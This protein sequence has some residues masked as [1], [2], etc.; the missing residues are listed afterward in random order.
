MIPRSAVC[1]VLGAVVLAGSSFASNSEKSSSSACGTALAASAGDARALDLLSAFDGD[2]APL[3][4]HLRQK[5]AQSPGGDAAIACLKSQAATPI[6]RELSLRFWRSSDVLPERLRHAVVALSWDGLP[7]VRVSLHQLCETTTFDDP[8]IRYGE[9]IDGSA[10][11]SGEV[12]SNGPPYSPQQ[13]AQCSAKLSR[14]R[15]LSLHR[16]VSEASA[17]AIVS[18]VPKLSS[19]AISAI[20]LRRNVLRAVP[21]ELRSFEVSREISPPRTGLGTD[22]EAVSPMIRRCKDLRRLRLAHV[23]VTSPILTGLPKE[24]EE[25]ELEEVDTTLAIPFARA[26]RRLESLE[27]L[28]V[29]GL[30]ADGIAALAPSIRRLTLKAPRIAPGAV[31]TRLSRYLREL[32]LHSL[33]SSESA[34]DGAAFARGIGKMT[35]LRRLRLVRCPTTPAYLETLSSKLVAL[36]VE[37]HD[38]EPEI[39]DSALEQYL[40][41]STLRELTVDGIGSQGRFLRWVPSTLHALTL[42]RMA[43]GLAQRAPGDVTDDD[44]Q[45]AFRRAPE[46][47]WLS[48]FAV[49]VEGTFL[50]DLPEALRYFEVD[51]IGMARWEVELPLRPLTLG[52][53]RTKSLT[54]FVCPQAVVRGDIVDVLPTSIVELE[55]A[56]FLRPVAR[57][58]LGDYDLERDLFRRLFRRLSHLRR[59]STYEWHRAPD[60]VVSVRPR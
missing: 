36:A 23:P 15:S 7:V 49:P 29:R 22:Q 1:V 45:V 60:Q 50:S 25:L 41:R 52:M 48:L 35:S 17:V 46:L 13:V 24:L 42:R 53:A 57:T 58:D 51:N 32:E 3:T 43:N 39:I 59:L 37:F 27:T 18:N 47:F 2:A 56:R 19:L 6:Q 33:P 28:E 9:I 30:D 21:T 12:L 44:L 11:P 55:L 26:M 16:S 34:E 40:K 5:F 8:W 4:R 14:F 31:V 38:N 54:W 10:I 20:H